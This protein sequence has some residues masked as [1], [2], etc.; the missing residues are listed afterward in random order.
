MAGKEDLQLLSSFV[1]SQAMGSKDIEKEVVGIGAVA[2]NRAT[3][4]G[5]LTEAIQSFEPGPEFQRVASGA[6]SEQEMEDLKMVIQ[7]TSRLLRGTEDPTGGAL[8]YFPK[9]LK[10]APET[11]LKR[12]YASPRYNFYKQLPVPPAGGMQELPQAPLPQS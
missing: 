1:Y 5:S 9:K 4:L 7:H 10:P 3:Q 12:T 6:L 2:M 11:G 8:H